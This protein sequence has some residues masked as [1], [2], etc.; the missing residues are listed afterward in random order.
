MRQV[1]TN[2][3]DQDNT[4]K[5]MECV[6]FVRENMDF[7]SNNRTMAM[8]D[9]KFANGDQWPAQMASSRELSDRPCLTVNKLD[10]FCRQVENQ[11]RQQRPRMKAH[12]VGNSD[13]MKADVATGLCRHVEV[14]S[15]ADH[16]YDTAF[17]YQVRMGWGYWRVVADYIDEKSFEQDLYIRR[18]DNPFTV[19]FDHFSISPDGSDAE[20][21]CLTDMRSKASFKRDFPDADDGAANFEPGGQGDLYGD[22]LTEKEIRVAEYFFVDRKKDTLLKLTTGEDVWESDIPT[23][24]KKTVLPMIVEKRPSFKRI[25]KWRLQTALEI[26]DE[27]EIPC[28]W[29]PVIPTYGN[30][31]VIDGKRKRFGMIRHARDPQMMVNFWETAATEYLA[32]STKAKWIMAEGQDEGHESEWARANQNPTSVLRY[33]MTDIDGREAGRPEQVQPDPPPTG[34]MQAL[35]MSTG[36]LREV[37]GVVDPAQRISGNVSGKALKGEQMQ[38]DNSTFHYF[39]NL[40]RS[41]RHT[42]KIIMN[43]GKSVWVEPN[44]VMRIIGDDGQPDQVTLNEQAAEQVLNDVSAMDF[45]IVMDTGPG[46]NSKRQESLDM[47]TQMLGTPLGEKIAQ[48]A[49]DLI[50]RMVDAPGAQ[51]IADRLAAGNPLAQID[52]KSQIPPQVQMMVKQLQGQL[53]QATQKIQMQDQLLKNRMDVVQAK[54]AAETQREHMR[55]TVKAHDI[56]TWVASKDHETNTKAISAQ[57]VEEIK[58]LVMLLTKHLDIQ[59]TESLAN[60]QDKQI[61]QS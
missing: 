38:S 50:V 45:D 8:S 34:L 53:Q 3:G 56:E 59:S 29:I 1:T 44:R 31:A 25:V 58:A 19:Y 11:Q 6:K 48:S 17:Y 24:L 7:E 55:Q 26:L 20:R 42:G 23:E 18:I 14:N 49:D 9:L 35:A 51:A 36:N 57:N 46:Y 52:D 43:W 40:T 33:K 5:I 32:L 12:P 2:D 28:K 4:S 21:V 22:W 37:L 41:I 13:V 54:E 10:A 47:F 16:A 15:D 27:K 39:D 30:E 60:S 61:M